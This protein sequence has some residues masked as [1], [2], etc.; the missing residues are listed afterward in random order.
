MIQSSFEFS[1][2]FYKV[3]LLCA[4]AEEKRLLYSG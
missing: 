4:F 1:V 3:V 2:E